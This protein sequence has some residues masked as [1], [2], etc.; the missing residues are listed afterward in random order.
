MHPA[1]VDEEAEV[2]ATGTRQ[3]GRAYQSFDG[4][5]LLRFVCVHHLA[6]NLK[7]VNFSYRISEITIARGTQ[8]EPTVHSQA[9]LYLGEGEGIL[10]EHIGDM[11]IFRGRRLEEFEP[12]REVAE[13]VMHGDGG[14]LGRLRFSCWI[15]SPLARRR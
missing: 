1:T 6:G 9:E 14:A 12:C 5:T 2:V 4:V 11:A 3:G 10:S 15:T 8:T 13:Q 7:A